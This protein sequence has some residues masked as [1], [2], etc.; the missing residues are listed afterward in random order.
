MTVIVL[1]AG[2][3]LIG[4]QVLLASATGWLTPDQMFSTHRVQGVPF[5]YHFGALWGDTVLTVLLA[6]LVNQYG[7]QWSGL[8]IAAAIV[9]ALV[10]GAGM[11]WQYA[12]DTLPGAHGGG[13][14][15]SLAGW[16]HAA[17]MVMALAILALFYFASRPHL[18]FVVAV[19]TALL[20]HVVLGTHTILKVWAPAWF[21]PMPVVD[22]PTLT[23]W[24][25]AAALLAFATYR[26][27]MER[28]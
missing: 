3:S 8:A 10:V 20:A 17:Y 18:R 5:M 28:R 11:H 21:P 23:V 13:G 22:S 14:T 12:H 9:V 16:L 24:L 26:T 4:L 27:T 1:A 19:S 25:G 15:L 2:L 7:K 6:Y